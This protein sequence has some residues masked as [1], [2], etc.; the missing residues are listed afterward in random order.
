[1]NTVPIDR[2]QSSE[3]KGA[4]SGRFFLIHCKVPTVVPVQTDMVEAGR[5]AT[6]G[7]QS[8]SRKTASIPAAAPGQAPPSTP[9]AALPHTRSSV[10]GHSKHACTVRNQS[11]IRNVPWPV[12]HHCVESS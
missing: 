11:A 1:M 12:R 7:N 9:S 8:G 2:E 3:A 10:S 4:P 5:T 6:V